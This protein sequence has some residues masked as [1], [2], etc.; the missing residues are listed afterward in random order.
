MEMS[1]ENTVSGSPSWTKS[2]PGPSIMP[3]SGITFRTRTASEREIRDHLSEC[4][5][6]F[7]PP[8][9]KKVDLPAYA[10]K[11]VNNA[12]TFEAWD[13]NRLAGLLAAYFNDEEKRIGY[14]T[15]MSVVP[16]CAGKGVGSEL[17]AHCINYA[18][19]EKYREIRLKVNKAN[20]PATSF[21]R[22]HNFN[23]TDEEDDDVIMTW[24]DNDEIPSPD[25]PEKLFSHTPHS[26]SHS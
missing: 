15:N 18:K 24:I 13:G 5:A 17:I 21:Y 14:I 9:S 10:R 20:V 16:R 2:E 11:I 22:K 4:D 26:R 19:K 3:I 12:V 7:V 8:L 1:L 6:G 25:K 23:R